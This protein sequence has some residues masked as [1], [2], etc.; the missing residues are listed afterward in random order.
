MNEDGLNNLIIEDII[1]KNIEEKK[2]I[3]GKIIKFRDR[4]PLVE[5][6]KKDDEMYICSKYYFINN[7]Y[8]KVNKEND[9]IKLNFVNNK[10][11][12]EKEDSNFFH[13]KRS[14]VGEMLN[15]DECSNKLHTES[16]N[17]N[18][19]VYTYNDEIYEGD[20]T[21]ILNTELDNDI[22]N[23]EFESEMQNT[24]L[25]SQM[26]NT[27]LDSE[28]L[29]TELYNQMPNTD[30]ENLVL[31]KFRERKLIIIL[32]GTS[33]GGKST[34]SCLLGLFLNIRR[35]LSTDVIR[36]V[37]R[38]YEIKDDKFLKFSTYES[39]KLNGSEDEETDKYAKPG[40]ACSCKKNPEINNGD[41]HKREGCN[42]CKQY[43]PEN[44]YPEMK[45]TE[46]MEK[47]LQRCIENY[48]KQCELLFNYIDDIINDH[49]TS[50]ESII[51]EGVH[52]NAD[53]ISKLSKKYPNNIIYFLVYIN[54]RETSIRRFSS[55]STHSNKEENKY[56][57]NI[58]YINHIQKYLLDETK[59]LHP[60]INYIENI[61]IYNSLE[62]VLRIIY[63]F[64]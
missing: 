48:S 35:I 53:M 47:M 11:N 18:M 62:K 17:D 52:V 1:R 10:D 20:Y 21:D 56:I 55:R 33:G 46:N 14:M 49:I 7:I 19:H 60:S 45:K 50:K 39:W 2:E 30:F 6:K 57:K 61:D 63:S 22:I 12:D 29:N 44:T 4:I 28:M 26:L 24:E 37:L 8:I 5:Y 31:T 25:C 54:D 13:T 3:V 34:L 9:K 41:I 38:K 16:S 58:N 42:V 59:Y 23:D 27:Q 43:N 36:E 64:G 15:V 51:I 32:S 40:E